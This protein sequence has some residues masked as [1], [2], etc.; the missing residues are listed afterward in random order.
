M[1]HN[2]IIEHL[3]FRSKMSLLQNVC[4][5]SNNLIVDLCCDLKEPR[6]KN[7]TIEAAIAYLF[8]AVRENISFDNNFAF[9]T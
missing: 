8:D 4:K 6:K 1:N 3:A 5:R 7:K 9:K 2:Y